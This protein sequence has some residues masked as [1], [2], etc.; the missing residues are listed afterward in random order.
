MMKHV[1]KDRV[2]RDLSTFILSAERVARWNASL[3]IHLIQFDFEGRCRVR[4]SEGTFL[5]LLQD[6]PENSRFI[7]MTSLTMS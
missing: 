2:F 3:P 5:D 7:F 6:L 1:L 4:E